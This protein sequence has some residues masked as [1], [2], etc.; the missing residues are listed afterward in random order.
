M[1]CYSYVASI[2]V[3]AFTI[4]ACG[5]NANDE[6]ST[7]S[8][9]SIGHTDQ[10]LATVDRGNA[11]SPQ[12]AHPT[13]IILIS[14]DTVGAGHVGGYSDNSTPAIEAIAA[15]GVRFDRFYAASSY[16][17]P[18]HM[19]LMTGLDPIEHGVV[20]VPSRLAP[21]DPDPGRRP[22]T[23]RLCHEIRQ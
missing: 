23:R 13:R 12:Q 19:S 20:N 14:L 8:A 4:T 5:P 6:R 9:G 17:L 3:L 15:D 22:A 16:T 2:V 10:R 1:N 7:T 21:R 18:S 11:T